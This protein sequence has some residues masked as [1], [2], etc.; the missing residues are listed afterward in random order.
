[1]HGVDLKS[2]PS[3]GVPEWGGADFEVK[4]RV[5]SGLSPG[6]VSPHMEG[7]K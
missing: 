6:V 5:L 1:M 2:G 3:P 4:V 7:G